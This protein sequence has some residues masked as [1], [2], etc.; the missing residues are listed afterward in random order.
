VGLHQESSVVPP[1]TPPQTLDELQERIFVAA[2]MVKM[3]HRFIFIVPLFWRYD[4]SKVQPNLE[5]SSHNKTSP[6]SDPVTR[7]KDTKNWYFKY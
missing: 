6:S 4:C 1:P 5:C 2:A 3:G 7:S